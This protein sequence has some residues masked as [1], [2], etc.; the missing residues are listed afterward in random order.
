MTLGLRTVQKY[1]I[2]ETTRIENGSIKQYPT[3]ET[4]ES[5]KKTNN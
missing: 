5:R 4:Q 2:I 3:E 1:N